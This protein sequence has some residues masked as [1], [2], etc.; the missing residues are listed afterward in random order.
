MDIV[1]GHEYSGSVDFDNHFDYVPGLD[2]NIGTTVV[3][4]EKDYAKYD[5][6]DED[7]DAYFAS[8]DSWP[9]DSHLFYSESNMRAIDE[10]IKRLAEGKVV[11]KTMEELLAME[12]D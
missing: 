11:V 7:L 2:E 12:N 9:D 5:D 4:A 8:I 6:E 3:N 1:S 10:A